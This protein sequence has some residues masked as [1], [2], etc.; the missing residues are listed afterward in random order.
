MKHYYLM[1][2]A[3]LL[4]VC[5]Y[6]QDRN[7]SGTVTDE[8]I[9]LYGVNVVVKGTTIGTT[10]DFD[11]NYTLKVPEGS[12]ALVFSYLG[13]ETSEAAIG[14]GGIL[15][16]ALS[17]DALKLGEV[18]VTALGISREQ[19][20]LG[21]ATQEIQGEDLTKAKE[22]NIVNS[23]QGKIAGV[24]I[25]G[26]SN[27]MGGSSKILIRGVNSVT[28]NNQP[29]FV[30]D[31]IPMD[32]SNFNSSGNQSR[33]AG[34]Y[35]YGNA[36]QDLNPDDVES[37][38]VLR[39]AVAA[40][41]YGSRASNGAIVIT[42]KKGTPGKKGIGVS[43]NT[44]Y[45]MQDVPLFPDYQYEYGGGYVT[46]FSPSDF[47]ID[48]ETV[49]QDVAYFGAD[50]SWGPKL[51][52]TEVRQWDSFDEWDKANYNQTRP[53]S[54]PSKGIEDFYETGSNWTN[55]IA[56]EAANENGS[57]RLSYTN[58]QQDF[59]LPNSN[60]DR[61]TFNMSGSYNLSDNLSS[62]FNANYVKSSALGRPQ[63]GYGSSLFSQFNQWWQVQLDFDR[64]S[65]YENPDGTQRTWN[66]RGIDDPNPQ[67]WDNPYWQ[68]YK[69]VQTDTRDRYF[70][71]I[72]VTYKFTDFLSL[73]GRVQTDFYTDKREERIANGGVNEAMYSEDIY[74]LQE[75]NM[76]LIL[77]FNKNLSEVLSLNAFVGGNVMNRKLDRN[78]N[79]T[80]GGLNVP[81]FFS[82]E[83]SAGP[84]DVTDYRSEKEIQSV[85]GSAS[86]GF[87]NMIYLDLTARNDWSSTLPSDNWSYFY[88]SATLSFVFTELPGL[89][90]N[91]LF[92]F[93]KL[94]A[95]WA[96]VGNDTDPYS[97]GVTYAPLAN[98][99]G[100]ANYT[101]PNT[102]NNPALKPEITTAWE[103][104][105]ELN[106][107]RNRA[108]IDFTYYDSQTEDQIIPVDVS[109][110]TGYTRVFINAG[111][112]TNRGMEL[113]LNLT[114]IKINKFKWDV[115]FNWARNINEVVELDADLENLPLSSLFG[116]SV[117][118]F[119]GE[120]YG[121]FLGTDYYYDN[122][123]NPIVDETGNYI[124]NQE[125]Q[126]LGGYL[127]DWTGGINTTLTFGGIS[128]YGLI[129]IQKGGNL[130]S[131]SNQ[132][133]K[134]SGLYGVTADDGVRESGI[135]A[136]GMLAQYDEN[137]LVTNEDGSPVSSGV[138]NNVAIG[139]QDYF[140]GNNGYFLNAS[141]MYDA[142]FVKLREARITYQLP[143]NILGNVGVRDVN[144]SL[145][146]RNLL[147]LHSNVPNI[148][149]EITVS[150]SNVQGFEG[151]SLPSLRTIGINLGFKF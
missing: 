82:L 150:T 98:F 116:V 47:V 99:N 113:S 32:N 21:Y 1:A 103:I 108:R 38:N 127:A 3:M 57:F 19:K 122:A 44:N 2:L 96:Q 4:C 13:Y 111:L 92:S 16:M 134:W 126:V 59:V 124:V 31:G 129:D 11:G 78:Y 35:D 77:N 144:V 123:G 60:F 114:P 128:L 80:V 56:L 97:L 12:E 48:G 109:A 29:L 46:S 115:G 26:G 81:D 39:G 93:G 146:G 142:S 71:N 30:V 37:I 18:V 67:Y 125:L 58:L 74:K 6:A 86:L 140:K 50:E 87:R 25:S 55:N 52:G 69:N 104:G 43:F 64:L 34:G 54:S 147:I 141:E 84:V 107:F 22:T 75:T 61:N 135:V 79:S 132:W 106:F 138:A 41:I 65:E 91:S 88:P 72:G 83:N 51:D 8:G 76:D 63:T 137:G 149:P 85:F 119:V 89:K 23:L 14:E 27:N 15:D 70:G 145:V 7:V 101:T 95:G 151:G 33:S 120:S 136:E 28:G 148:D 66:R 73:T 133:G 143:N 10:T 20:S 102:R 49:S 121:T 130:Y 36:I 110:A 105:T 94:R 139:V 100:T 112:M 5:A 118:A 117:N 53:W 45:A 9:P 62:F 131:Y 68:R 40:A 17:E 42:T 24:Q 90:D